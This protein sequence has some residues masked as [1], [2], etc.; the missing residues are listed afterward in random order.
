M[1]KVLVFW[2]WNQW[3]KYL[4]YFSKLW[5][6]LDVVTR[7][8]KVKSNSF[9][10]NYYIFYDLI[11][12]DSTF[13]SNYDFIVVA[14]NP[15]EQLDLVLRF[16]YS[17]KLNNKIII[18]KPVS[19]D[20]EFLS[21]LLLKDNYYFFIDEILLSKLYLNLF[22]INSF[23]NLNIVIYS[24]NKL[25][26]IDILEHVFWWFLL[27][28]NFLN[29]FNKIKIN[30]INKSIWNDLLYYKI[31]NKKFLLSFEAW[32]IYINW[33]S[34]LDLKFD[35]S[36]DFILSIN[37]INNRTYKKNFIILRKFLNNH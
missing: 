13:F 3:I 31:Y 9:F 33:L 27:D 32:K 15:Y 4:N 10:C 2:M 34:I 37:S 17:K 29:L 14:V 16:I 36:L 20:I 5:Y 35:N 1:K 21:K 26:Y 23:S 19:Y 30:F 8:W 11:N 28:S 22:N 6:S 25:S 7:S 18:D 24:K 12:F